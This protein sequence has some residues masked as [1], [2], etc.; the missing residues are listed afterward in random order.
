MVEV[1]RTSGSVRSNPCSSRT[2]SR[3]IYKADLQGGDCFYDCVILRR[4]G[5]GS[6]LLTWCSVVF[7]FSLQTVYDQWFITLYNLMYTSLPV[8]GMSLFDQVLFWSLLVL[9]LQAFCLWVLRVTSVK[10]K[11][12]ALWLAVVIIPK[13]DSCQWDLRAQKKD[14]P[15]RRSSIIPPRP[16]CFSVWRCFGVRLL[17]WIKDAIAP[18][19]W[20]S[21]ISLAVALKPDK[22]LF[23]H[24][25]EQQMTHNSEDPLSQEVQVQPSCGNFTYIHTYIFLPQ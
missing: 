16:A 8:L 3:Q 21:H 24:H 7:F 9:F 19:P 12:L 25:T 14:T 23:N 5:K 10:Q 6:V 4:E 11:Q 17:T 22:L 18:F 13:T 15:R 2:V 20:S 1:G